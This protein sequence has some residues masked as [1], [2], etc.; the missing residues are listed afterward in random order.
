MRGLDS[1][2]GIYVKILLVI[3]RYMVEFPSIEWLAIFMLEQRSCLLFRIVLRLFLLKDWPPIP[4]RLPEAHIDYLAWNSFVIERRADGPNQ[5][6]LHSV[7]SCIGFCNS[8]LPE[9][10]VFTKWME[11][12]SSNDKPAEV[13][14]IESLNLNFTAGKQLYI[15]AYLARSTDGITM[16]FPGLQ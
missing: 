13:L 9:E 7:P 14:D 16:P 3:K 15:S 4:C 5:N 6:M 12:E 8:K 11:V 10:I 1:N 2:R